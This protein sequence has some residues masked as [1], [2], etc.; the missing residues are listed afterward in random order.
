MCRWKLRYRSVCKFIVG[1]S[2]TGEKG[3]EEV[4]GEEVGKEFLG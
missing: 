3:V 1:D 4:D 2:V